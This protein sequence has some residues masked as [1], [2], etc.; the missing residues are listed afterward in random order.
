[1]T[2]A[3]LLRAFRS[4]DAPAFDELVRRHGV[5]IKAYALRMLRNREQA[6]EVYEDTFL[7]V[8]TSRGAWEQRGTVRGWLYTIA[9]RLC[10]DRLRRQK[11][12]R[13][14]RTSVIELDRAR[15]LR[16]NPE[17]QALLGERARQLEDALSQLSEEH[18][19]V[20]LL[21]CV[22]GLSAREAAQ[23]LDLAESQIH[24]QLSY[25]RR[26][27]RQQLDVPARRTAR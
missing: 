20:L 4:G 23:A 18:R 25:A 15:Q 21:R 7:K 11:V 9:H 26:L 1:M 2:D 6:E 16:P 8:A 19:Q 10:L 12:A 17:A 5:A 27:L 13:L 22:H 14:A 3:E 24:S